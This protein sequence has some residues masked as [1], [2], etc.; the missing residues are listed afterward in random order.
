MVVRGAGAVTGVE[1]LG[2]TPKYV[3]SFFD[4]MGMSRLGRESNPTFRPCADGGFED[5]REVLVGLPVVD[6]RRDCRSSLDVS[7]SLTTSAL[8][9][10]GDDASDAALKACDEYPESLRD[11]FSFEERLL[12]SPL[13]DFFLVL[14]V[15]LVPRTLSPSSLASST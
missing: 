2:D 15:R 9:C 7:F 3:G 8:L 14:A 12:R 1:L 4:R 11:F 5:L 13:S 10:D 6:F